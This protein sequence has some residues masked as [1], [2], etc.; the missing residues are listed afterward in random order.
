MFVEENN[1]NILNQSV[2]DN[3]VISVV[4]FVETRKED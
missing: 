3:V 2:T 4:M 1:R